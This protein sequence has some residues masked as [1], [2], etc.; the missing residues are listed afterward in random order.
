[1][2]QE[3]A[4]R[5]GLDLGS[6]AG[7]IDEVARSASSDLGLPQGAAASRPLGQKAKAA[8]EERELAQFQGV[9]GFQAFQSDPFGALEQHLKNTIRKQQAEEENEAAGRSGGSAA[10]GK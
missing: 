7:G 4:R 8:L 5:S 10:P 6:L 9:V 3:E 2:K 1:M